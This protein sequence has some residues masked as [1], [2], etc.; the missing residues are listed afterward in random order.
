M[1]GIMT[2][3]FAP[4]NKLRRQRGTR[5]AKRHARPGLESLEARTVLSGLNPYLQ[6]NLVSD[7]AGLA[8]ITDSSLVNPWGVSFS[9]TS[10]FWVSNQGT[11][12]STLY[13]A[14]T[15][16]GISK[17]AALTV[18]IPTTASGPQ[19]PT[20]Q[21]NNSTSSFHGQRQARGLHLRQPQRHHL[22]VER[23][24]DGHR[25]KRRPPV[26]PTPAWPSR[27]T[28]RAASSTPP[29]TRRIGSTSSTVRSRSRSRT[30]SRTRSST[31]NS[32]PGSSRST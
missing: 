8:Q 5:R 32:R 11:N 20:G 9:A 6:T 30:W 23:G 15:P 19:G 4:T 21:V 13:N 1:Y 25:S 3:S 18:G 24:H 17:V 27:P 14:E 12:T 16:T 10:P 29:T 31:P 7:V 26:P 2:K 28:P 22:S